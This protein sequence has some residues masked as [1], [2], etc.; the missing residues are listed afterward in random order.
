MFIWSA[1]ASLLI[2]L[3]QFLLGLK[4]IQEN[5]LKGYKGQ[6]K[7]NIDNVSLN[8]GST[9]FAG[10]FVGFLVNGFIFIFILL[11]LF[12]LAVYTVLTFFSTY[13][14]K[15]FLLVLPAISI[16]LVKLAIDY[17]CS[18]F[19]FLQSYGKYLAL[20]N[21]RV[22]SLF[23]Y[24]M[25]FLDCVAGFISAVARVLQGAA[26]QILFMPRISYSFLSGFLKQYDEGHLVFSG[27]LK[28]E[29]GKFK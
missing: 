3:I 2:C 13:L 7:S 20:N 11:F 19:I 4:S 21:V 12:L 1:L 29:I 14:Y 23:V 10:Y 15:I 28:M 9:H 25:F 26:L 6:I 5:L 27:Y 18:K 17:I 22:Y 24:F 8:T 16:Y